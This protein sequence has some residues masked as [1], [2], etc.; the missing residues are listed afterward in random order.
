MPTPR[1]PVTRVLT[2]ELAG[3]AGNSQ[4]R[5]FVLPSAVV[6]L[7]GA[8][9]LDSGP[10][11]GSWY[12][13]TLGREL[14]TMLERDQS[15]DLRSLL[16]AAI[17]RIACKYRLQRG[18][19]PSSTVA[20]ARWINTR[21]DALVLGDS[22][23]VAI[24]RGGDVDE[25]CDDRLAGVAAAKRRSYRSRLRSGAGYD[26]EHRRLLRELYDEERQARNTPHGYSI[27]EADPQAAYR[28][29]ACSWASSDLAAVVLA[30]DGVSAGVKRYNTFPHWNAAVE[31]ATEKGSNEVL[32]AVNEAEGADASGKRW[33]RSKKHDDKS[34]AI[35]YID[36]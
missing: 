12:A 3:S 21:I 2:A 31:T 13:E 1:P 35:L 24:H 32:S 4:D 22:S 29:L 26:E 17:H 30:S 19:G 28:A 9:S 23:V 18:S 16:A 7:D 6:L 25:L 11:D 8:S 5:I 10:L 34:L 33:P 20:I 36:T 15:S 14:A 27:A